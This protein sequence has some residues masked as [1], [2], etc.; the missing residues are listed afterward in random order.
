MYI[1]IMYLI[2]ILL[3]LY[4]NS[5]VLF[6]KSLFNAVR[7]ELVE[8]FGGLTQYI[9]SP[10]KGLWKDTSSTEVQDEIII[11]EIMAEKIDSEWWSAYKIKLAMIFEQEELII[12][13]HA[14]ELL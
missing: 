9:R 12:R 6:P 13:A 14:I 11:Y 2:Q 7:T 5:N 10:A 1:A 4:N 3:P 8:T